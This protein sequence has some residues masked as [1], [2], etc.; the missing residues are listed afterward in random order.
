[1]PNWT[2]NFH[3]LLNLFLESQCPL[4]Q[5]PTPQEFCQDCTRQLQRCKLSNPQ[6]FWRGELPVFAW[7]NYSG[8]LKRAIAALKY[9]NQPQIAKPLGQWLAKAWL[10][11]QPQQR[12]IVVPIPLH[13][14]KLKMR[15]YNQAELLAESFC[16]FTGLVLQPQ[17]IKRIKATDAQFSLSASQREHNLADAFVLGTE[18]HRQRPNDLVLLLDDIYTTGAT[19]RSAVQALQKQGISVYGVV[20]IATSSRNIVPTG[21]NKV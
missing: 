4:C 10:D 1:M 15:G 2:Q 5:R 8:T 18:F 19:V 7:G 6:E 12:L 21:K 3:S 9:D 16:D 13:A 11:S 20:A 17:G 14:D